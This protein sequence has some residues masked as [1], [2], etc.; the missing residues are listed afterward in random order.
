MVASSFPRTRE[1]NVVI[2]PIAD[3]ILSVDLLRTFMSGG[4]LAVG[5]ADAIVLPGINALHLFAID[6]RVAI[7]DVHCRG[8]I[9]LASS[10]VG[11]SKFE[12]L[13]YEEVR[14][15][16]KTSHKIAAHALFSL[17]ELKAY[18]RT[19][20]FQVLWPDH[21]IE[22]TPE[23]RV[24]PEIEQISTWVWNKGNRPHRDSYS[25]FKDNG[26]DSTRL[27]LQLRCR[28]VK[29]VFVWGLAFDYCVGFT[30]IDAASLG[31]EVFVITDLCRSVS[32]DSEKQMV[33]RL[34]ATPNVHL[35]HSTQMAA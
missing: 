11:I 10:F 7:R 9:S 27:D 12:C 15:W 24:V 3:A 19:V 34:M 14:K 6:R 2:D 18:L 33:D 23:S 1:D 4:G 5:D 17:R 16:T 8:H 35:I 32:T 22:G 20:E 29:R 30:A 13:T 31:F 25:A 28:H 21:A 26:G